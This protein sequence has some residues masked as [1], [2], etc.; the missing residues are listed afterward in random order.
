M[1]DLKAFEELQSEQ[2]IFI[3]HVSST[4]KEYKEM[5]EPFNEVTIWDI[6]N[7][8]GS[9]I[10]HA[11]TISYDEYKVLEQNGMVGEDGAITFRADLCFKNIKFAQYKTLE[12]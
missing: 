3:G 8:H 4:V 9:R 7:K 12:I 11:I 1:S 6:R 10:S 5:K 2:E